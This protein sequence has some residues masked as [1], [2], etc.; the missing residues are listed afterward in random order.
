MTRQQQRIFRIGELLVV[1]CGFGAFLAATPPGD[2]VQVALILA[3]ITGL[4]ILVV[5]GL[6]LVWGREE[7]E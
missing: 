1:G 2:R 4:I 5:F 6:H 7:Y 3:A